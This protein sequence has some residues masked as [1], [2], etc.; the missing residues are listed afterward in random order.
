MRK[1]SKYLIIVCA[2]LLTL[3]VFVGCAYNL[4]NNVN[5]NNTNASDVINP[6]D[7][8]DEPI[9]DDR[10]G[11]EEDDPII[12]DRPGQEE[13]DPII[14]PEPTPEPEPEPEPE[15]AFEDYGLNVITISLSEV[16]VSKGGRYTSM[17]EVG[18][19]LYLY[20]ELP[21]NYVTKSAFKKSNYTSENKLSVGGDRFGNYEGLLPKGKS[22]TECDINYR[23][24]NRNK[25]RIVF[26]STDWTIF[27]TD[28]HYDSFSILKFVK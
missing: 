12:D 17:K 7:D 23:G 14:E 8:Y 4:G 15:P 22:Y 25:Y 24:G 2:L 1:F 20:H 5:G 18:A 26:S 10:P 3:C 6:Y 21:V 28:D 19:Y 11:Q 13:D 16:N 9:I 27:Y